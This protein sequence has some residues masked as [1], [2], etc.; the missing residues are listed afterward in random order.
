ML[1]A[2]HIRWL[3]LIAALVVLLGSAGAAEA[4]W[5]TIQNDT[6]QVIVV[7]GTL[8]CDGQAK[9]CKPIRLLPGESIREFHLPQMY[10]VEIFDGTNPTQSLYSGSLN[11]K[12][13]KQSFSIGKDGQKLFV[14]PVVMRPDR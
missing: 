1:A 4:G 6:N 5:V 13:E 12:A 11:I 2:L 10:K 3:S 7:Q 9:R 8:R 14:A